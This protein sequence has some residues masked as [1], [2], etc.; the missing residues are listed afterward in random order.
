MSL[1][2]VFINAGTSTNTPQGDIVLRLLKEKRSA[3]DNNVD[4]VF[5]WFNGMNVNPNGDNIV[6]FAD[7]LKEYVKLTDKK[8][9]W[10]SIIDTGAMLKWNYYVQTP[11]PDKSDGTS[12]NI[13]DDTIIASR[14]LGINAGNLQVYSNRNDTFT[15]TLDYNTIY[16][17][18]TNLETLF[19]TGFDGTSFK[20]KSEVIAWFKGANIQPIPAAVDAYRANIKAYLEDPRKE[21]DSKIEI[22]I[23]LVK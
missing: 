19:G 16:N 23:F 4:Y 10:N 22:G 21:I 1:I 12:G 2:D 6:E 14:I 7:E 15:A 3:Y 17:D 11:R 9:I 20:S 8:S 5:A 18:G 13:M